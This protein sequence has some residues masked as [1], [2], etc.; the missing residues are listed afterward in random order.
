MCVSRTF[1]DHLCL[2]S[3]SFQDCLIEWISNKSDFHIHVLNQLP[4]VHSLTKMW[5]RN[6]KVWS[7]ELMSPKFRKTC[8]L[9]RNAATIWFIFQT[10][11]D[12]PGLENLNFKFHDFP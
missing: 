5:N 4:S 1:Q 2:F 6:G 12:F 11:R 3:T 9:V 8:T 10:F 7:S